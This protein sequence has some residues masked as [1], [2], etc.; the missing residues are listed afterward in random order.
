MSESKNGFRLPPKSG[1]AEGDMFDP[2]QHSAMVI[3]GANGAG[4]T[5]FANRLAA[6]LGDRAFRLNALDAL[7]NAT[8]PDPQRSAVDRLHR[9]ATAI[10]DYD[11]Q[12]RQTRLQRL[13]TL[14]VSDELVNLFRFKFTRY[15]NDG[16]AEHPNAPRQVPRTH[17][18]TLIRFWQEVFPGNRVLV[19]SGNI[20]FSRDDSDDTFGAGR[21]S[22]G[23]R[24]VLYYG[25]ALLYAPRNAVVMV[26]SPEMFL[27]PS[28]LQGVWN[29]L[30]RLR[31]D[32]TP[33]YITHDLEFAASRHGA[34]VVWVR[35]CNTRLAE[36]DY[37]IVPEHSELTDQISLAIMGARKPVLF[38]EGDQRSIDARLYPLIFSDYTVKSLGSCN[39]VIEAT[40]TFNDLNAFHHLQARG[41][42]DRD[43]RDEA[44]VT[45]LRGKNIMVPE[46]AEIENMLLLPEI[47]E[48]VATFRGKD[49]R[50][51]AQS[52]RNSVLKMFEHDLRQQALQHTRHRVKRTVEYRID[53]R[54]NDIGALEQHIDSLTG[55][56]NPRGLYENFCREFHGYRASGDYRA[57][58][59]V[60]NQKSMLP[61][62]N[63]P[64]LCG[65]NNKEDYIDT[66]MRILQTTA[67]QAAQI[68]QAVR[69]ALRAD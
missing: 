69:T 48:A 37:R 65:L 17:M 4:K 12:R 25:A 23:E 16:D 42:V 10:P 8:E 2:G 3:V 53:G 63:I 38:I 47:V 18:D 60:Y 29:R 15:E 41:I 58:L 40:R 46:V 44:E 64:A 30:E 49:G 14:I 36:W 43:R 50:R 52:V 67:P 66:V 54:F 5:R 19:D 39:K 45:Y 13:L 56:I 57:V 62:C 26:D 32:C 61:G 51:V 28:T 35:A 59:R 34:A 33:V 27:H 22:D 31:P 21:L 68:R 1:G 11:K 20:L 24:A 55:E 7:Y 9:D 6:D